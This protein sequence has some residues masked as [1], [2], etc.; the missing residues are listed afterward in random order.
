MLGGKAT[1]L[2]NADGGAVTPAVASFL[3]PGLGFGL[4]L[5]LTLTLAVPLTL[6]LTLSLTLANPTPT[7]IGVTRQGGRQGAALRGDTRR[8][9]QLQ[10]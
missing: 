3:G 7:P 6:T 4:T 5:T 8:A 9:A 1:I 2:A 10:P